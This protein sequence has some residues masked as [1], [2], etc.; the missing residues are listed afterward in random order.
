MSVRD[1]GL[2]VNERAGALILSRAKELDY[3][4]HG[5]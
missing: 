5:A 1:S 4:F 2:P 3:I